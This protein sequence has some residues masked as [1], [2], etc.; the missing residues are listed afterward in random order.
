MNK[1]NIDERIIN[2]IS[3]ISLVMFQ[4]NFFDIFF[5]AI[6]YKID[7]N[8][9]IIN[10]NN[11]CFGNISA[12]NLNILSHKRDYSWQDSSSHAH[13]H[14]Y[15]YRE[16]PEAKC[17]IYAI[18]PFSTAYSIINNSV[19]PKDYYGHMKLKKIY[20]YNPKDFNTWNERADVEICNF[21]KQND[22]NYMLVKGYGIYAYHR[23]LFDLAKIVTLI[24]NSIKILTL[25]KND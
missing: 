17:I 23:D 24:E 3:K 18:P 5:G 12:D 11:A 4:K 19:S 15:I 2:N 20:I 10:S 9:F 1:N 8:R 21:F 16:I 14:S 13:I 6:S 7:E 25:N 22:I